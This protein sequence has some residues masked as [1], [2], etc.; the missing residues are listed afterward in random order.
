MKRID[1]LRTGRLLLRRWRDDDREPFAALNGDPETLVYFPATLSR[2]ESDAVVDRIETNFTQRGWG[3]WALEVRGTGQFIGFTGLAPLAPGVPGDGVEIGWRLARP[4]WRHGY[5]TEAATA[6]RDAAFRDLG[7]P[8]LWSMTA[9]LNAPSQ[10]VMRRIGM[11]ESARFDHPRV[12]EGSPLR[13]HVM[14]HLPNP[15]APAA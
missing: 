2:A 11:T 9:V 5:A 15:A 3:L 10:A 8:E 6:V 12:A 4:A 14:F 7:L 1:T 13:P